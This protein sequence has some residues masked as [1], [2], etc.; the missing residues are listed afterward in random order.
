MLNELNDWCK[1]NSMHV[2]SV[3]SNVVHFRLLSCPRT[4]MTFKCGDDIIKSADRY[5]Y[6]GLTL[7]E[8]KDYNITAKVVIQSASRALRYVMARYKSIGGMP[9]GVF[10]TLFD[11]SVWSVISNG[12]A[13]W[14]Y[15]SFA[16]INSIQNRAMRFSLGVGKVYQFSGPW[17][18]ICIEVVLIKNIWQ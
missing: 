17:I 15:K 12:S 1:S 5:I 3:K 6:L 4:E 13:I 18:Y 8:H 16:C 11:S 2:S 9:H 10:S 14:G 7:T